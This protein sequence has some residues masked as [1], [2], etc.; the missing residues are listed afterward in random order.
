MPLAN[1]CRYYYLRK[2]IE[3]VKQKVTFCVDENNVRNM[4]CEFF[5]FKEPLQNKI[6]KKMKEKI[7]TI[8]TSTFH[9]HNSMFLV[10]SV[11]YINAAQNTYSIT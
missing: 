5:L 9:I 8:C 2:Y 7:Y 3:C 6:L 10:L 11:L 1:S 4:Y